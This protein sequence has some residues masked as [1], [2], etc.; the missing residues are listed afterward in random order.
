MI[1]KKNN[2]NNYDNNNQD[3]NPWRFIQKYFRFEKNHNFLLK[4]W[5]FKTMKVYVPLNF[6]QNGKL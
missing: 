5:I 3:I 6:N 2:I 4:L 1:W